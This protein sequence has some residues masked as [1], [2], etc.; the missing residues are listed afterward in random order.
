MLV[1]LIVVTVLA[2]LAVALI[3]VGR[4]AGQLGLRLLQ[5]LQQCLNPHAGVFGVDG[6]LGI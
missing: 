1:L 4:I 6:T 2:V 3:A 5:S